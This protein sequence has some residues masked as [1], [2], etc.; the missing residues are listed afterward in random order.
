MNE[1]GPRLGTE[2]VLSSIFS[3]KPHTHSRAGAYFTD[4]E[5]RVQEGKPLGE[6]V[7]VPVVLSGSF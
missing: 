3:R 1:G 6:R 5:P 7:A 2:E 4:R